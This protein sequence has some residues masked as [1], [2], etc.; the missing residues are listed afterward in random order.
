MEEITR[1]SR[2]PGKHPFHRLV[3][4]LAFLVTA[5]LVLGA[6]VLIANYDKLNF[7]SIKRWFAYRSISRSE[8]GQAESFQFDSGASSAFAMLDRD[9]L[10]CSTTGV[11]LYSGSGQAYINRSATLKNPVVVTAAGTALV[12]DAGGQNLFVYRDRSEVFSLAMEDG[13]TLLSADVNDSGWLTVVSHESGYKGIVTVYDNSFSP[14]IQISLSSRF[15]MDA[16]VSPDNKQVA[17]LTIGLEDNAFDSRIDLYRLERNSQETAPDASC[18]VG[19]NAILDLRWNSSG[20]WALGESGLSIVDSDGTL[21]GSY[22]YSGLY[23]KNFSLEGD[24]FAALLLG[25]YR[26]GTSAELILVDHGGQ[27]IASL[28]VDEQVLSLSSAGRY[29]SLLTADRLDIY[30]SD[31]SP[32]STLNGTQ[33]AQKV[34]QRSDGSVMLIGSTTAHLYLPQ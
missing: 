32:Y 15:I 2:P 23:L 22:D 13:F 26:A 29:T 6:V 28:P 16:A 34:L 9:L 3:R 31:L 5:A 21:A 4:L 14:V 30:T 12:Y 7:D 24:G 10:V 8:S 18:S 25:K 27:E 11:R 20:I 1:P 17:I 19:N 33:S